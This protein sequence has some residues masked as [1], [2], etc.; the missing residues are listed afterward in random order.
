MPHHRNVGLCAARVGFEHSNAIVQIAQRLG[1]TVGRFPARLHTTGMVVG[2]HPITVLAKHMNLFHIRSVSAAKAV[3]KHHQ[4]V[5]DRI[6][7][8]IKVSLQCMPGRGR[9]GVRLR[10]QAGEILRCKVKNGF[11]I[12]AS[13]V[14]HSPI[15]MNDCSTCQTGV[16]GLSAHAANNA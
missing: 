14:H 10:L 9:K 11:R 13:C 6:F 1:K 15:H 12:V 5:G 8:L 4:S 16:H 7:I 2:E 3:V